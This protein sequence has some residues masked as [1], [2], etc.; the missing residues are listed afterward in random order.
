MFSL[1]VQSTCKY[2]KLAQRAIVEL[3]AENQFQ[4]LDAKSDTHITRTP[5]LRMPHGEILSGRDVFSWL[6]KSVDANDEPEEA[7]ERPTM[8]TVEGNE[9]VQKKFEELQSRFA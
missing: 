7:D 8:A 2:S 9:D 6:V 5:T 1:Y 4:I 3:K